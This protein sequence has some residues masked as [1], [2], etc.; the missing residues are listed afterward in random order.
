MRSYSALLL[1]VTRTLQLLLLLQALASRT[2]LLQ[3]LTAELDTAIATARTAWFEALRP[4][5]LKLAKLRELLR[6]YS[7][8]DDS[9]KSAATTAG[10]IGTTTAGAAAAA[11]AATPGSAGSSSGV[12]SANSSSGGGATATPRDELLALITC[13]YASPATCQFFAHSLRDAEL[14]RLRKGAEAG[15]AA[16]EAQLL[17]TVART[18]H[19]LL[20]TACDVRRTALVSSTTATVTTADATTADTTAGTTA[21]AIAA[22]ELV[23][24]DGKAGDGLALLLV[25][26]C[27][28]LVCA[29]ECA[30]HEAQTARA[31]LTELLSWLA[32]VAPRYGPAAGAEH[33][34]PPAALLRSVMQFLRDDV[35]A[36]STDTSSELFVS[37]SAATPDAA[38]SSSTFV[39]RAGSQSR[40]SRGSGSRRPPPA[41]AAAGGASA[42]T[43]TAVEGSAVEAL[44][45]TRVVHLLRADSTASSSSSGA[46]SSS[47]ATTPGGSSSSSSSAAAAA[48]GDAGAL[49]AAL[50]AVKAAA[51]E[52]AQRTPQRLSSSSSS[53]SSSNSSS[54]SSMQRGLG[55]AVLLG[56]DA[57]G[58]VPDWP[59]KAS[60]QST[61]EPIIGCATRAAATA[62]AAG[63]AAAAREAVLA[64]A[65]AGAI[66][67]APAVVPPPPSSLLHIPFSQLKSAVCIRSSSNSSSSSS[68]S[69]TGSSGDT[70]VI[71]V[72][73]AATV[74]MFLLAEPAEGSLQTTRVRAAALALPGT[75][76]QVAFYT[77][78]TDP[79]G[80]RLVLVLPK[81]TAATSS[82]Q[83]LQQDSSSTTTTADSAADDSST[84]ADTSTAT[85]A[86]AAGD[87]IPV[88][89]WP[90][91]TVAYDT[92]PF[93]ELPAVNMAL[94]VTHSAWAAPAQR[95]LDLVAAATA[96][97]LEPL[98]LSTFATSSSEGS[99]RCGS[100]APHYEDPRITLCAPRGTACVMSANHNVCVLDM[101][102]DAE[103]EDDSDELV[104][105]EG[106]EIIYDSS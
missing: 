51:H 12:H 43:R 28:Q 77:G 72:A 99:V 81:T 37:S 29:T 84:A 105:E 27:Q 48:A 104:G 57:T 75:V 22:V 93:V 50:S 62:A 9:S 34:R 83:L 80:E 86:T 19:A 4:L 59:V 101:E 53:S 106:L 24:D 74:Y 39:F 8:T 32:F 85:A 3:S 60:A 68:T 20:L 11:A 45:R 49:P 98:A 33:P 61:A 13:G 82:A 42:R 6:T 52:L 15:V 38:A 18:A 73:H 65:A 95:T 71:A 5:S 91:L 78:S 96:A 40:K 35:G 90:L 64:A 46:G 89:S 23:C 56:T 30:L 94:D 14:A 36:N 97:G 87:E 1:H 2:A 25:Q 17:G 69:S 16:V 88:G 47:S 44:L 103:P 31:R 26:R 76:W 54:S 63:T 21:G 67:I 79:T 7:G 10:A 58:S 92:L 100:I 66:A 102:G 55:A 41:A 70:T